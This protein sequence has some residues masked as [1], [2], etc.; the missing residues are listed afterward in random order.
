ML[1]QFVLYQVCV[2]LNLIV[3]GLSIFFINLN[4]FNISPLFA[5]SYSKLLNWQQ[6]ILP[7]KI[8]Q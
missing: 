8:Q 7:F 2:T 6:S 1:Y 5:M 3:A 4:L